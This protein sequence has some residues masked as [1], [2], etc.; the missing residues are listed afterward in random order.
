MAILPLPARSVV[1]RAARDG[2][3]RESLTELLDIFIQRWF[4]DRFRNA[5]YDNSIDTVI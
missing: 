3:V 5:W 4:V 2:S 1:V